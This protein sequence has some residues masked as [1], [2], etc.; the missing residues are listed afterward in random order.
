MAEA[1]WEKPQSP[2]KATKALGGERLKFLVGGVLILA[3]V[4]YLVISGTVSGARY[5]ITI[6]ELASNPSYIGQTVRVAGAVDGETI[7]FDS[8][9]LVITFAVANVPLDY[10]NLANALHEALLNPD[11]KRINVRVEGQPMPDLL[12]HEAQAIMT[13]T[14]GTD[15]VFHATE[16]L[17]KCPTRFQE[18]QPGQEIAQPGA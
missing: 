9:N 15:G 17:L 7:N 2:A 1:T 4:A 12:Q 5:Y 3:A 13:G 16:L 8:Q 6:E 10:D 14:L 11:A 18:A